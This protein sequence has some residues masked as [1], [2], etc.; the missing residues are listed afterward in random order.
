MKL[1]K[2]LLPLAVSAAITAPM[3]FGATATQAE[4][5]ANLAVSNMY[6][7]RGQNLTPDG[8]AIDGG[9]QYD[10]ASGFYAGAWASSEEGGHETD[11]YLGYGGSFGDFGYDISY[12]KYL[13]PEDCSGTPINCSLGDND[14]SEVILS[15]SFGPISA[16]AYI[17]VESGQDDNVYYTL[18]GELDKFT[19]T[20][21]VWDLENPGNEYKHLT[22]GYAYNDSL[23]FAVSLAD[24]ESGFTEENGL[25]VEEDPLFQVRY[26]WSF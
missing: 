18:S 20:F 7:W 3:L 17:N 8:G 4:V 2:K 13:Y 10:N 22:L 19:L 14:T 25:G 11:L 21:G 1:T 9:L 12:L 24:N 15:G 23:S 5:S 26:A 16:A 6:L